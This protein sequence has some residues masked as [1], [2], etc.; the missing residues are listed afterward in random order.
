MEAR[1]EQAN[2]K[3]LSWVLANDDGKFTAA[4]AD[5]SAATA[6]GMQLRGAEALAVRPQL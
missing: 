2:K 1:E 4:A 5:A 6:E 3:K